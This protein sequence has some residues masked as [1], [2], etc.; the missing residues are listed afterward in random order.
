MRRGRWAVLCL[1]AAA[2]LATAGKG[3]PVQATT[4][5]GLH[6]VAVFVSGQDGY[7]TYRI[8]A[9]V[10]SKKGTLLAFCEGRRHSRSDSGDIDTVLKRSFDGGKTWSKMQILWDDGTNTVGNPCAL[11]D[12]DTGTIWLLLSRNV[13]RMFALKSTD[14]G[15]AWSKPVEITRQVKGPDW[16]WLVAGP[17]H[18]VQL[19]SG[20]FIMP[21]D[22]RLRGLPRPDSFSHVI[23]S[24]DGGATWKLGGSATRKTNECQ[25]VETADGALYLSMRSFHGKG[26][27]AFAWSKDGGLTWSAVQHDPAL[28]TPVCQATVIRYTDAGRHDKNRILFSSPLGARREKM[29]LWI[30]TDECKTWKRGRT[31]H[32]GPSAYSDL[33]IT[34]DLQIA[35]FYERGKKHPYETLTFARFPLEWLTEGADRLRKSTSSL[36][37]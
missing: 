18:G 31:I 36:K 20:R 11:V 26:L 23:Y 4:A 12:R 34:P 10:V 37:Q 28:T 17:G 9:I 16:T 14:D 32:A 2:L 25:A 35:C 6:E 30:S 15:A 29:T 8:P 13:D 22:H 24:D 3:Q 33:C 7:H 5:G 27:R 21:C 19:R 1:W